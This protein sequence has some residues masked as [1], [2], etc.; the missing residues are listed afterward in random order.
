MSSRVSSCRFL[1]LVFSCLASSGLT[2][3]F[4]LPS[5]PV[6]S[7]LASSCLLLAC[8]TS[9]VANRHSFEWYRC[10]LLFASWASLGQY[11][12]TV[13]LV[14]SC[15]LSVSLWS[16][17]CPRPLIA[18]WSGRPRMNPRRLQE[19]QNELRKPKL[20]PRRPQEVQNET[21]VAQDELQEAPGGGPGRPTMSP[22]RPPEVQ[23]ERQEAPEGP[24]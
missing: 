20:S 7:C 16:R 9:G 24:K 22:R 2:S 1:C 17:L 12:G 10:F 13:S 4:L 6:S 19:A 15:R 18:S 21:Q 5:C 11:R 3:S 14:F 23:N 8:L